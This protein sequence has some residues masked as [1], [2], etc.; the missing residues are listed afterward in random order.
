MGCIRLLAMVF[1]YCLLRN[2]DKRQN[3][4]WQE[5]HSEMCR[6]L[7]WFHKLKGKNSS[8]QIIK[9]ALLILCI[10]FKNV[11]QLS[12]NMPFQKIKC[13]NI[14]KDHIVHLTCIAA[15]YKDWSEGNYMES[16]KSYFHIVCPTGI[17]KHKWF[18]LFL[19]CV[20]I[21]LWFTKQVLQ[22]KFY[23]YIK[24]IFWLYS[25]ASMVT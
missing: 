1:D 14:Q 18:L 11:V 3:K 8:F 24:T 22:N 10:I 2:R 9:I 7:D 17:S 19:M 15:L 5:L 21:S 23:K 25:H 13:L 4:E 16:L 12:H 20:Y 6:E